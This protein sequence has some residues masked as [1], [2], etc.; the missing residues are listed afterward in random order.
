MRPMTALT[1]TAIVTGK[2]KRRRRT[3]RKRKQRKPRSRAQTLIAKRMSSLP[4]NPRTNPP[5][6]PPR[7]MTLTMRNLSI[8]QDKR[9]QPGVNLAPHQAALLLLTK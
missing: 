2:R 1:Q 8:R 7:K 5:Q 9:H 4:R 3:K 6:L